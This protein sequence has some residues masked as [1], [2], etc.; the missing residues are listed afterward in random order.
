MVNNPVIIIPARMAATRLP[1]KPLADIAG[2][3]MIVHV[4]EAAKNA[5]IGPVFVAVAEEEIV[6]EVDLAGG[7][8]I[9]TDPELPSGTDR[10][11]AALDQI[12]A[13][14]KHDVV[15]NLQ[16]DIPTIEPDDIKKVLLP[17]DNDQVDI[18]T[19]VAPITDESEKD[20]P[21]VVKPIVAWSKDKLGRALY[22][23]R[24]KA[25]NDDGP[26]YHHIGIYAYRREAIEKFRTLP[27][28]DLEKREKLE[29][30]RAMENGMRIDVYEIE[31]IP[32]GV[33][34]PEDLEKARKIL[35][36]ETV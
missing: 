25:P 24:A 19:L 17:L 20:N 35:E 21:S 23:T 9:L 11:C 3:P 8:A 5:N 16:G 33:D 22:F 28:S 26:H 36:K 2:K 7:S 14:K 27:P 13:N 31:N 32:F 12:D 34:T 6:R 15:I 18:A 1:G 4:M 30:L 29:Q 10:I